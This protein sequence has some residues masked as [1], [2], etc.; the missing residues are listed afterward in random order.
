M[1]TPKPSEISL[2][3]GYQARALQLEDLTAAAHLIN[4]CW[5]K[6]TGRSLLTADELHNDLTGPSV[7]LERDTFIISAPDGN[8]VGY[9]AFF[10]TPPHVL[11]RVRVEVHPDYLGQGIG[12]ALALWVQQRGQSMTSLAP[13]GTRI[14]VLQECL[15]TENSARKLL[16]TFG[17]R[18]ARHDLEMQIVMDE[19]PMLPVIPEGLVIRPCRLPEEEREVVEVI[20]RSFKG[21]WGYV[22]Q[23]F[24]DD[25]KGWGNYFYNAP[26]CDPELLLVAQ[27]GEKLVGTCFGAPNPGE[28]AE[29]AW[30]FAL[31]VLP[32]WRRRGLGLALL[33]QCFF[34][35]HKRAR[36][37]VCLTVDAQNL[38]G[39]THLYEKAGMQISY[40][41]DIFELEIRPGKELS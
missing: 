21:H 30:V 17:Y 9:A 39:A 4:T 11:A 19:P 24:E 14:V 32:S 34:E 20:R 35:L 28:S 26:N 40:Q 18:L 29:S 36:T 10:D 8:L 1:N 12:C 16:E 41:F 13:F 25:L 2:P 38:S 37:K 6:R 3:T 22:E 27:E 15:S 7:V 33:Q 5:K 31:G 23:P